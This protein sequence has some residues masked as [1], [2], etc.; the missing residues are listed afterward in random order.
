MRL[1]LWVLTM[2]LQASSAEPAPDA[3]AAGFHPAACPSAVSTRTWSAASDPYFAYSVPASWT[4]ADRLERWEVPA[5]TMVS[6]RLSVYLDYSLKA[7]SVPVLSLFGSATPGKLAP[8]GVLLDE[9]IASSRARGD[10]VLGRAG[11]FSVPGIAQACAAG[12]IELNARR[13]CAGGPDAACRRA[14]YFL[15]CGAVGGAGVTVT[16]LLPPYPERG[17]PEGRAA[18][19]VDE[20]QAFLC[21]LS[22]RR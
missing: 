20:L 8:A 16:A 18:E 21:G 11:T 6:G 12:V 2:S 15:D 13:L 7:S 17:K 9:N 5:S 14:L 22:Y 3:S 19:A 10:D 1:L 4:V